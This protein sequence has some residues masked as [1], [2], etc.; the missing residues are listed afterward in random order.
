MKYN[1][2]TGTVVKVTARKATV[3]LEHAPQESCGTCCACSA[4][5]GEHVVEVDRADLKPGDRVQV[6]IPQVSAYLSMLLV[7]GLPLILFFV[8]IYVGR[9]FEDAER[10]GTASVL[11]GVIGLLLAFALAWL[12]NRKFYGHVAAE[13]HRI[14]PET[15]SSGK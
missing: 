7:F 1:E 13:A 9:L 10:I 4:M 14:T 3:R 8:G 15:G 2:D 12:I 11:G 5:A 6:R